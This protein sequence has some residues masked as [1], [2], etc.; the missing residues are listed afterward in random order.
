MKY[1]VIVASLAAGVY[2]LHWLKNPEIGAALIGLAG[3]LLDPADVVA[4]IKAWRAK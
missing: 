3:V 1:V 4:A 2:T